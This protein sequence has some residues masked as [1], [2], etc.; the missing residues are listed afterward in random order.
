MKIL[1]GESRDMKV[2][3][4]IVDYRFELCV[5]VIW[6]LFVLFVPFWFVWLLFWNIVS[7]IKDSCLDVWHEG[8]KVRNNIQ[9][10]KEELGLFA[11]CRECSEDK[12]ERHDA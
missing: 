10:T 8:I 9:K 6:L 5:I 1:Y 4:E 12:N 2:D 7:G 3:V 11:T